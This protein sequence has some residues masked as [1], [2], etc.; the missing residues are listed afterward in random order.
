MKEVRARYKVYVYEIELEIRSVVFLEGGKPENPEKHK[1]QT[2]PS[3]GGGSR[4]RTRV[5]SVGD[6]CHST[7]PPSSLPYL[8]KFSNSR[9]NMNG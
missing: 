4:E 7:I 9:V 6:E 8:E 5:T 3:Y 1:Q 2:L